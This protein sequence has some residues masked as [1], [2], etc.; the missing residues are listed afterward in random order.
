MR[1]RP[2]I[3]FEWRGNHHLYHGIWIA[4]FGIFQYYMG[5]NNS[6][7]ES[8]FPLWQVFIGAGVF[9]IIDDIVEHT[10]TADTPLRLLYEKIVRRYLK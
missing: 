10:L 3:K 8:L 9:M 5:I 7:L 4:A 2:K 1:F 6:E